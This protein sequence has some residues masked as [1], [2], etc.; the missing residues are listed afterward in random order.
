VSHLVQLAPFCVL[1]IRKIA[2]VYKLFYFAVV[3]K[4]GTGLIIVTISAL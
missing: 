1:Y 2:C 3:F 4:Y